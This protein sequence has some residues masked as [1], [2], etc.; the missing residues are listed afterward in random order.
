MVAGHTPK[1][2]PMLMLTMMP[3]A[4]AHSGTAPFH[5]SVRRINKHQSV[6]EN[7]RDDAAGTGERHRF[8]QKLPGDVA[9][10]RADR[11]AHA[12]L[13]SALGNADQ[14]DVHH[15]DTADQQTDRT[16]NDG[17]NRDHRDDV[18][19]FLDLHFRGRDQEI[20]FAVVGDV[21]AAAQHFGDLINSLI[22]LIGIC[23]D[24]NLILVRAGDR[25]CGTCCKE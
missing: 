23:L 6:D 4:A 20:I 21:A 3:A 12:D 5:S 2:K 17:G 9:A 10:A 7:E 25:L 24:A 11:F 1:I 15:A 19:E 14:H 8:E 16:E 22:E 13:A 18:V